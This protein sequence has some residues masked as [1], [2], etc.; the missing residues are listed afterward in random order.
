MRRSEMS[1]ILKKHHEIKG[2]KFSNGISR[3]QKK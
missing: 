1:N 2:F 3:H